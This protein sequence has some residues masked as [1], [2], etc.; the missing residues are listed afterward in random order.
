MQKLIKKAV[1]EVLRS[2]P[3]EVKNLLKPEQINQLLCEILV[4]SHLSKF[5]KNLNGQWI[6]GGNL[7][8][9]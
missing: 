2:N 6:K 3:A 7:P 4:Y 5:D 9:K 1:K 8:R